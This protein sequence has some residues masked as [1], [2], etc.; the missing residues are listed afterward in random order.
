[1]SDPYPSPTRPPRSGIERFLGGSP[2]GVVVR[3]LLL[4]LVV[5]FAMSV[6]GIEPQDVIDGTINLVH[7]AMRDDFGVFRNLGAY[8]LTG[9]VLVVP[10]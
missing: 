6:F 8:V 9:A 10:I 2:L 5:G 7:D 1:M 3:L 4:S